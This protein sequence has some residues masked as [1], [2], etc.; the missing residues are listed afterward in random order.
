MVE[1]EREGEYLWI[2]RLEDGDGTLGKVLEWKGNEVGRVGLG[3]DQ[4]E[5]SL[6]NEWVSL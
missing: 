3:M 1:L 2:G 4:E 5:H 6:H